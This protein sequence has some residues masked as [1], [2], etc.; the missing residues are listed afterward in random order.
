MCCPTGRLND[1]EEGQRGTKEETIRN[2]KDPSQDRLI[3]LA[4]VLTYLPISKSTWWAGVKSG[5]YPAPLKLSRRVTCWR[6]K[7]VLVLVER[8]VSDT[9]V[10]V[11]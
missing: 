6:L 2:Q 10:D 11:R 8:G 3:R 1:A 5:T 4:E 9:S 7:D